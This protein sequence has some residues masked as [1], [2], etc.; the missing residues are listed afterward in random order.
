FTRL[1]RRRAKPLPSTVPTPNTADSEAQR[2]EPTPVS[3]FHHFGVSQMSRRLCIL[4]AVA[5]VAVVAAA[6]N[7]EATFRHLRLTHPPAPKIVEVELVFNASWV[8]LGYPVT[9]HDGSGNH[10]VFLTA[11]GAW[12]KDPL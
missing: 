9:L 2:L 6:S 5:A 1:R 10:E 4:A 12:A 3:T 11:A 7:A 8:F